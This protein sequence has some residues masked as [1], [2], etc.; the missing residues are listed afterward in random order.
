[1]LLSIADIIHGFFGD[2]REGESYLCIGL[3]SLVHIKKT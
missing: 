1:M 2:I 3:V